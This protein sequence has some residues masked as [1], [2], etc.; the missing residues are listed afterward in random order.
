LRGHECGLLI[1]EYR[2]FTKV[3][4]GLITPP[5]FSEVDFSSFY[6][7]DIRTPVP[8]QPKKKFSSL[9]TADGYA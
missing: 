1:V 5:S 8:P 7:G 4:E 6:T 9:V 2:D 3:K